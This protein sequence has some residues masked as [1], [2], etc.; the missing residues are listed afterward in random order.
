MENLEARAV[1]STASTPETPPKDGWLSQFSLPMTLGFG[2]HWAW[3]YATIY[4]SRYIFFPY[5][6]DSIVDPLFFPLLSMVSLVTTLFF[7]GIRGGKVE[8]IKKPSFQL[9]AGIVMVAGTFCLLLAGAIPAAGLYFS[10]PAGILTGFG[11]GTLLVCWGEGFR[12]RDAAAITLNTA[13]SIVVAY[14]LYALLLFPLPPIIGPL[15][16]CILPIAETFFLLKT[17]HGRRNPAEIPLNKA[18]SA[19]N[20]GPGP[21][22]IPTF[23]DLKVRRS[24]FAVRIGIPSLVFG[25]A[26]GLLRQL[27]FGSTSEPFTFGSQLIFIVGAILGSVLFIISMLAVSSRDYD[28]IYRILV[29][30]IAISLFVVPAINELSALLG[31]I[32]LLM[33][34]ICFE[35][36]MWVAF[37]EISHRYRISPLLVFG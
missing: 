15:L 28:D 36:M 14:I 6:S 33:S 17:L 10:I 11:S 5:A 13:T 1:S 12:R 21:Y 25:F 23:H 16:V 27:Y 26:L 32:L 8:Y 30:V 9:K 35:L 18:L 34:V 19:D 20:P 37:C 31:L 22:E 29:P 4:A 2:L 7:Y 3:V 24:F